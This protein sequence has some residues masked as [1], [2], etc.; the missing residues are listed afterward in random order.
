MRK[1]STTERLKRRQLPLAV[2]DGH[3]DYCMDRMFKAATVDGIRF[4]NH[5]AFAYN[6]A[7]SAAERRVA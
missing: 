2:L 3:F 7:A 1:R 4:W 6:M 5:M